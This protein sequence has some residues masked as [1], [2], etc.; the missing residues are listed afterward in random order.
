MRA[1][2]IIVAIISYAISYYHYRK[3]IESESKQE[4]VRNIIQ[5]TLF[6]LVGIIYTANFIDG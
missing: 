4:T 2:S 3:A 5:A 1:L 6:L